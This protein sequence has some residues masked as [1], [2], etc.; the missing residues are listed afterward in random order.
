MNNTAS[1]PEGY[2]AL[3]TVLV[4]TAVSLAIAVSVALLSIGDIQTSLS[5]GL[6]EERYLLTDGCMEDALLKSAT[7]PGYVGGTITRPEGTCD[8]SITKSGNTWTIT[9]TTQNLDYKRTLQVI[10]T[11]SA[12]LKLFKW[13][14]I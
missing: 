13:Q 9:S 1:P 2:I 12:S 6:G 14:E 7:T 11:R 5:L 4:I 8:I 3:S 10:A